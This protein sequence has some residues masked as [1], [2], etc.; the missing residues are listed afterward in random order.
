MPALRQ[1]PK[2]KGKKEQDPL[3]DKWYQSG[4]GKVF[5]SKVVESYSL[6]RRDYV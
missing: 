3:L 2:K 6:N 1:Q 5:A 4:S